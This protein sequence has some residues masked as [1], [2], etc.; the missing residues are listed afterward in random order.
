MDSIINAFLSQKKEN[1]KE[2]KKAISQ[3]LNQ[4]YDEKWKRKQGVEATQKLRSLR[5]TFIKLSESKNENKRLAGIKGLGTMSCSLIF[6]EKIDKMIELF[7]KTIIDDN[8]YIRLASAN[9][10]GYIRSGLTEDTTITDQI[11]AEV[12]LLMI[13][14][15]D[16]EN[17]PKKRKSIEIAL[18]KLY[19]PHLE[20][21]LLNAGYVKNNNS[22]K[23]HFTT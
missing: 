6:E 10:F 13:E 12:Y 17:N 7:F 8:G 16:S 15:L 11:Y 1:I 9:T 23:L 18:G 14:L 5:D 21:I 2:A 4:H 20:S 22:K 19:C 3:I